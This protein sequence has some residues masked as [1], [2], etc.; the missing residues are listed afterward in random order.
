LVDKNWEDT[1]FWRKRNHY[2]QA[3]GWIIGSWIA[4]HF[5][6]APFILPW[7][8]AML[9]QNWPEILLSGVF[10]YVF[11]RMIHNHGHALVGRW[12][13]AEAA[14][15][16]NKKDSRLKQWRDFALRNARLGEHT[17]AQRIL[18]LMGGPAANI[19]VGGIA[20]ILLHY[21][22][23]PSSSILSTYRILNEFAMANLATGLG[24]WVPIRRNAGG[25]LIVRLTSI[26]VWRSAI[27][28]VSTLASA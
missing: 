3:M 23:E 6:D 7:S 28:S 1:Y 21:F 11:G 16:V 17:L 13:G 14:V 2:R 22:L 5:L 24:A 8:P 10:Y 9:W 19:Q 18:F 4:L 12:T 25:P 27:R 26:L 20:F 15:E